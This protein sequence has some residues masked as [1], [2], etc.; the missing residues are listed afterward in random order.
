MLGW[1]DTTFAS[2]LAHKAHKIA[3]FDDSEQGRTLWDRVIQALPEVMQ[4]SPRQDAWEFD[5]EI[6]AFGR[7]RCRYG[8]EE[9]AWAKTKALPSSRLRHNLA[10]GSD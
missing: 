8:N 9:R 3:P 6:L 7:S 10:K 1:L 2:W 5:K 4:S